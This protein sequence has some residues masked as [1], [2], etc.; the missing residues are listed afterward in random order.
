MSPLLPA[1]FRFF[2]VTIYGAIEASKHNNEP[3][4]PI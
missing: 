4:R 3:E 2:N 1:G